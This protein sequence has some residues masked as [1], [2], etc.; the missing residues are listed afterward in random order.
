MKRDYVDDLLMGMEA[1]GEAIDDEF[2]EGTDD[3]DEDEE[4]KEEED[5]DEDKDEEDESNRKR[6]RRGSPQQN[7]QPEKIYKCEERKCKDYG[8]DF[9]FA[10]SKD[11]HDRCVHI[12]IRCLS[13]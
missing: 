3:D 12:I 13:K 5:K 2:G 7:L 8:T 10:S 1:P 11:R 9:K 6:P 4:E